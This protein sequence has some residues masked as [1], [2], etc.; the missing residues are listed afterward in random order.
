MHAKQ[1]F[2]PSFI[3]TERADYKKIFFCNQT[4]AVRVNGRGDPTSV[5]SARYD[6]AQ[7]CLQSE[8]LPKQKPVATFLQR[9]RMIRWCSHELSKGKTN[10]SLAQRTILP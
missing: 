5:H 9:Q 1:F 6:I 4:Q 2:S 3:S 8:E 10:T 7:R